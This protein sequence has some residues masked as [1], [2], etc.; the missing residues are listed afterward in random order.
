[1][2][3]LLERRAFLVAA[4]GGTRGNA[5]QGARPGGAAQVTEAQLKS[6]SW[7]EVEKARQEGRL[8]NLLGAS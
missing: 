3:A 2:D 8:K 1:M 7:Q 5:D 4:Q 6:M